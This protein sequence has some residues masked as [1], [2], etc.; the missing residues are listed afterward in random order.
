[1]KKQNNKRT[2]KRYFC[3]TKCDTFLVQFI[4]VKIINKIKKDKKVNDGIQI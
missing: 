3:D 1:M 4:L 2:K